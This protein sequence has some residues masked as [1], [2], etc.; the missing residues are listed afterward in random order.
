MI[1]I[2]TSAFIEFLNRTG[3]R[4]DQ[5]VEK[6]IVNDDDIAIPDISLTEIL[7]GIR[8]D[9]EY[10]EIKTSLLTFP[11]LT[12]KDNNSYVSAADLYR[13]CRKKGT[14]VRNTVDLLVAQITIEH[15][16]TLL[17]KDR[18][19]EAIAKICGLKLYKK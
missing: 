11:V 6:L 4:E 8:D 10:V 19:F 3:S 9:K 14:T 5:I 1:L 13:K 15:K 18:D 7:Q 16:A 17:H 2:D 12:L